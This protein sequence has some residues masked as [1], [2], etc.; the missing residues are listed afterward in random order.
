VG[1]GASAGGAAGHGSGGRG[2]GA[3]DVGRQRRSGRAGMIRPRRR[4]G[5]AWHAPLPLLALV[6]AAGTR[7]CVAPPFWVPRARRSRAALRTA[8]GRPR[9]VPAVDGRVANTAS[10]PLTSVG[11][12]NRPLPSARVGS[13]DRPWDWAARRSGSCRRGRRFLRCGAP[14]SAPRAALTCNAHGRVTRAN[15]IVTGEW[16]GRGTHGGAPH[17]CP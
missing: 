15:V 1:R 16:D 4:G 6:D 11:A 12:L 17:T 14:R 10:D 13:H 7:G 9:P 8:G 2:T 3:N 5:V